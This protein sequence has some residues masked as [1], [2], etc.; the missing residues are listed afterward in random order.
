M[1]KSQKKKKVASRAPERNNARILIISLAVLLSAVL[2]FGIVLGTVAIVRRATAEVYYEGV[3]FGEGVV[4]YLAA[5]YKARYLTELSADASLES[6]GVF[7]ADSPDFWESE[8]PYGGGKSFGDKL[9]EDTEYYIKSIA[10]KVYLFDRAAYLSSEAK[11]E[12]AEQIEDTL[13]Y[14]AGGSRDEFNK[15]AEPMGFDFSD[16]CEAQ[17]LLYKA[18]RA[19]AVIYGQNGEV[20]SN[21]SYLGLCNNYFKNNY[22]HVK[23][24]FIRTRDDFAVDEDGNR[25]EGEGGDELRDLTEEEKEERR[26]DIEAIRAAIK[27][28]NE[29]GDGQMSPEYFDTFLDKYG[30]LD[31]Y[32]ETGLYLSEKSAF[33]AEFGSSES[34]LAPVVRAALNMNVG[35]YREVEWEAGIS[36]IYKYE[37]GDY[38]YLGSNVEQFFTDFYPSAAEEILVD[39]VK[40]LAPDVELGEHFGTLDL[41]ALPYNWEF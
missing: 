37:C 25:I 31:E 11:E 28:F 18:E 2:I 35:E 33:T 41:A 8:V 23:I 3:A 26:Q 34:G 14:R 39:S 5:T 21:E 29:N 38:A 40:T 4:N 19:G 13:S 30:Y 36:F 7:P 16:F 9:R 32:F 1:N 6:F 24:L 22:S 12:I 17:E 10:I 15:K 20:L 27:A